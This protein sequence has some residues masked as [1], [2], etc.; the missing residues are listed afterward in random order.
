M[1]TLFVLSVVCKRKVHEIFRRKMLGVLFLILS[2]FHSGF[3][4]LVGVSKVDG[5]S[6]RNDSLIHDYTLLATL[7]L[8]VPLAGYNYF[9][10]STNYW[11]LPYF[12]PYTTWMQGNNGSYDPTWVKVSLGIFFRN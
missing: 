10:R 3:G 6:L 8:G 11:P 2:C 5:N 9:P 1:K 12:G 7:P 4:L